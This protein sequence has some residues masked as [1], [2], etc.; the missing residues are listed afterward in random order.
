MQDRAR[1]LF[2]SVLLTLL[3]II[4]ALALEFLWTHLRESSYLWSMG[5]DCYLGWIQVIAMLLGILQV[6]LM[7]TS[8][9]MRFRWLPSQRDS[10]LPFVIG[11]LEFTLIDLLGP[12]TYGPWFFTLALVFM[13]AVGDGQSVFR[14]ARKDAMNREFFESLEPATVRDFVQS[15]ATVLGLVVFAVVAHLTDGQK[16]IV[17]TGLLYANAALAYQIA[18]ASRY[19]NVAMKSGQRDQP[20][21]AN[22][23]S[24]P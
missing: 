18:Q 17:L 9:V 7:Y 4:Q 3:S 13:I 2:P 10:V 12:A 6:W 20:A 8:L 16:W 24:Q 14:R 5:W 23:Q 15:I 21:P 19:W 22:D 1:Q 11:I